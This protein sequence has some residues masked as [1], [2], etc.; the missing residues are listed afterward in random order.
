MSTDKTQ[1]SVG[2]A[3]VARLLSQPR[4]TRIE[5]LRT[6]VWFSIPAILAEVSSTAMGYIDTAM[7][8]SLGSAASAAVGLVASSTWLLGGLT[9]GAAT[10][11]TVQ[12]AQLVGAERDAD[13]RS[14]LRQA[15]LVLLAFSVALALVGALA[16]GPL[17]VWLG[18]EPEVLAAASG[19]FLAYSLA[20]PAVQLNRL[21]VGA[22]QCSGNMRTPSA[23]NVLMCLL[24]VVFN[25]LLIFPARP[26]PL[27]GATVVLPGAG[28]G[29]VGA[30][31]G[32]A[33]AEVVVTAL[34]LWS[35]CVRSPQLALF[36][37]IA[38]GRDGGPAEKAP[39]G[40][41]KVRSPWRPQRRRL[42]AAA[43]VAGPVCLERVVMSAAQI[44][45]TAIVAPLGTVAVAAHSLAVTAE[46]VCYMPGYGIGAAAT[47]LV[48]QSFGAGRKD[49]ARRAACTSVVLGM[50][51]M[52]LTGALM[53]ALAPS[54]FA[55][56]TPDA[57]V[58]RLGAA[59]LR[60]ELPAEPLFAASIV[61]MGALR[62]AGDTL[63]PSIM[64][65][66]TMWGVRITLALLLTP[67]LGLIGVW[68]AMAVELCVRGALFL[69]RLLRGRW[70]E[71]N[72]LAG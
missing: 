40:L 38:R 5:V 56:L 34:L 45:S 69:V 42:L 32:T 59:A 41:S 9:T 53:F 46:G 8:G 68:V 19:Y 44:V 28:L 33:L 3:S 24:D 60:I 16:S 35:A 47:T 36:G 21:C 66:A 10:G 67:H 55:L 64:N 23:L 49:L 30:A 71:R 57:A 72:S 26:V 58:Q 61:A 29:V 39:A 65:L 48:G 18:G 11:F 22:L 7:V 70:L 1:R 63:V 13:A 25:F 37:R 50:A 2:A 14:V 15:I 17:P 6:V 31:L 27:F 4:P 12:I 43:R 20:L 51:V 54:V 62:G 52:G